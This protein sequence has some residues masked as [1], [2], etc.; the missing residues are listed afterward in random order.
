MSTT[1]R[2]KRQQQRGDTQY[3]QRDVVIISCT[4]YWFFYE[5]DIRS[6]LPRAQ[7]YDVDSHLA[8][9]DDAARGIG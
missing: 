7:V 5:H 4:K 2:L 3:I 9:D 8:A 6:Y 1:S